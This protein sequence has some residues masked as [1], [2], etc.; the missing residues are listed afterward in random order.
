VVINIESIICT[1]LSF[2]ESVFNYDKA[3]FMPKYIF[4]YNHLIFNA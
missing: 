1:L 3:G 2:D 4:I